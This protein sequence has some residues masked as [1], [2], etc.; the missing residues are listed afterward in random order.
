MEL[1]IS[2][3]SENQY[4][5]AGFGLFGVGA[6]AAAG[7]RLTAASMVLFRRHCITTLGMNICYLLLRKIVIF[8]VAIMIN[9]IQIFHLCYFQEIPCNDKSYFW[10]LDWL[11]KRGARKTQ[12]LSIR[13]SF[14]ET[15]TM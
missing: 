11:T 5:S 12:H 15:G 2:T 10:I 1:V 9:S 13:T 6:L 7:R 14:E 3:L 4:F 8:Y